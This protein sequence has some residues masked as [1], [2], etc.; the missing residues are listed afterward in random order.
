MLYTI[1]ENSKNNTYFYDKSKDSRK[2]YDKLKHIG[3]DDGLETSL[4][5]RTLYLKDKTF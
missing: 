5:R 4:I 1:L 2:H 3:P